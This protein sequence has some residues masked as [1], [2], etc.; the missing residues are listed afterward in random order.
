MRYK[1]ADSQSKTLWLNEAR[2]WANL[3]ETMLPTVGALSWLDDGKPWAVFDVEEVVYNVDVD[4]Y[5]R[6]RGL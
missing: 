1:A 5:F 6:S 3:S 4:T 2:E